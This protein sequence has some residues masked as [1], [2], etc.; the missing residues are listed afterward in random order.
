MP[1]EESVAQLGEFVCQNVNA[2]PDNNTTL[3]LQRGDCF[4]I[5]N[6]SNPVWS[7]V[8]GSDAALKDLVSKKGAPM[9]G[10]CEL[11]AEAVHSHFRQNTFT[12]ELARVLHAPHEQIHPQLRAAVLAQELSLKEDQGLPDVELEDAG[13]LED[14][15]DDL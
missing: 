9:L 11:N 1:T 3:S 12:V 15:D 5:P 10:F 7:D 6:Q 14:S 13:D 8:I 2:A 4:W